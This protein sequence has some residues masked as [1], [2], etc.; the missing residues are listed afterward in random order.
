MDKLI[1]TYMHACTNIHI[2]TYKL[3]EQTNKQDK[4]K[5]KKADDPGCQ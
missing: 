2:H 1:H 4:V 3:T 5:F